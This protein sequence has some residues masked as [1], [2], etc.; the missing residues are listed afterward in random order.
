MIKISKI[1]VYATDA[2]EHGFHI[3]YTQAA[4]GKLF[5]M[6]IMYLALQCPTVQF[7]LCNHTHCVVLDDAFHESAGLKDFK[8]VVRNRTALVDAHLA[9]DKPKKTAKKGKT[10]KN[11]TPGEERWIYA[12]CITRYANQLC[13]IKAINSSQYIHYMY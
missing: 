5:T 4:I 12:L 9:T 10:K 8:D 11:K 13:T 1:D 6:K 7:L 2:I 3:V